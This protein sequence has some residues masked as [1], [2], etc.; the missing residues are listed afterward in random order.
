MHEYVDSTIS[1]TIPLLYVESKWTL[2]GEQKIYY[3][4][5]DQNKNMPCGK[6]YFPNVLCKVTSTFKSQFKW[7]SESVSCSVVSDSLWLPLSVG[8]APLSMEFSRQEKTHF[9]CHS[10]FFTDVSG[11]R[12]L[13][14]V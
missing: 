13:I 5:K 8:Q 1:N 7:K 6:T 3:K 9:V 2:G 10:D 4:N 11:G 14:Y 12:P